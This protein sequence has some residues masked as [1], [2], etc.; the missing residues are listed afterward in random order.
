MHLILNLFFGGPADSGNYYS[1]SDKSQYTKYNKKN[2]KKQN[3][4]LNKLFKKLFSIKNKNDINGYHAIYKTIQKKNISDWLIKYKL[5]EATN[6][7]REIK[8]INN[9]YIDLNEHA[10]KN[11]D[12]S[13]AI[14]RGLNLFK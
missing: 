13:R 7:N 10:K 11:S 12:L 14:K 1:N 2:T 5:L 6:C 3:S 4:D 9:L 8:W